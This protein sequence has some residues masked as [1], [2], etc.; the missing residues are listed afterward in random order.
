LQKAG[1]LHDIEGIQFYSWK[2]TGIRDHSERVKLIKLRDQAG[3]GSTE[4][5]LQYYQPYEVNQEIQS[6]PFELI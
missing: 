5:T 6:L 3:H 4:Q 1:L 2:D